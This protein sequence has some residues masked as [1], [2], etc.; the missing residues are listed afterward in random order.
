MLAT[1]AQ[2][3]RAANLVDAGVTVLIVSQQRRYAQRGNAWQCL[4]G[5][6]AGLHGGG[7]AADTP[8]IPVNGFD[9]ASPRTLG[10]SVSP[11]TSATVG[12]AEL[13]NRMQ[14]SVGG[15]CNTVLVSE[16]QQFAR[17]PIQLQPLAG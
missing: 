15:H 11:S 6:H 7:D 1:L 10:P 14:R 13:D 12:Q 17:E 3:C 9:R 5:N 16:V 8:E 4:D 2:P